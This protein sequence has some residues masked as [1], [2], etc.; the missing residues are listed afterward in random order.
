MW[1]REE[2]P[3]VP[4]QYPGTSGQTNY[5]PK[6]AEGGSA[7]GGKLGVCGGNCRSLCLGSERPSKKVSF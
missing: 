2:A 7:A 4:C 1:E 3:E 6:G 5:S